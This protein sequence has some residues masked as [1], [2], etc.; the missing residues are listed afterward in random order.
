[1][2]CP[3]RHKT[4]FRHDHVQVSFSVSSFLLSF[5]EPKSLF[6]VLQHENRDMPSWRSSEEFHPG[7]KPHS[8]KGLEARRLSRPGF[9]YDPKLYDSDPSPYP[10]TLLCRF[11]LGN[12]VALSKIL[13]PSSRCMHR[14]IASHCLYCFLLPR[15]RKNSAHRFDI[16]GIYIR[17]LLCTHGKSAHSSVMRC[18]SHSAINE[19]LM[20]TISRKVASAS[21]MFIGLH[22]LLFPKVVHN[23]WREKK[24]SLTVISK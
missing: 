1:M 22:E 24:S 12:V 3:K 7:R 2:E 4:G 5:I 17:L 10:L 21:E 16:S 23:S 13:I 18:N 11:S 20:V 15:V 19:A 8:D 6:V 9:L 14:I